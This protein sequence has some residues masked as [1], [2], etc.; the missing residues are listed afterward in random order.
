MNLPE[1]CQSTNLVDSFDFSFVCL[2]N[3]KYEEE[4]FDTEVGKLR[5][6]FHNPASGDYCLVDTYSKDL[7]G[8]HFPQYTRGLWNTINASEDLNLLGCRLTPTPTAL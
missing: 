3:K 4:R 2:P 5:E 8:E 7:S 6:R 1:G